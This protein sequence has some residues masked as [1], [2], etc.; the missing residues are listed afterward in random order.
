VR[1]KNL[2]AE[3]QDVLTEKLT[4]SFLFCFLLPFFAIVAKAKNWKPNE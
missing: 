2:D 3:L 4:L 1:E